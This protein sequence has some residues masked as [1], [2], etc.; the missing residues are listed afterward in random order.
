MAQ[1][2]ELKLKVAGSSPAEVH[3]FFLLPQ[4]CCFIETNQASAGFDCPRL[5]N[6]YVEEFAVTEYTT[7]V[8]RLTYQVVC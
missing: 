3:F 5:N 2:V 1:K 6:H 4:K 7:Q 8:G